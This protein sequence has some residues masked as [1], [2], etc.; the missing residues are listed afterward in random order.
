MTL[1]RRKYVYMS[2]SVLCRDTECSPVNLGLRSHQPG[3]LFPKRIRDV[4]EIC[5]Y[6]GYQ[7]IRLQECRHGI[8]VRE[9][10]GGDEGEYSIFQV[11]LKR[12]VSVLHILIQHMA[13][14]SLSVSKIGV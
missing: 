11:S 1:Y 3:I 13:H 12:K 4:G 2:L 7:Y 5:N 6:G 8:R 14:L 10:H 9:S